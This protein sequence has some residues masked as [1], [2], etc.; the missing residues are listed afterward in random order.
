M[1]TLQFKL[2]AVLRQRQAIEDLRQRELALVMRQRMILLDQLKREQETITQSKHELGQALVGRVDLERVSGFA[3]FSGQTT[4]RATQIVRKLASLES[5]VEKARLALVEAMR[6]RKALDLLKEKHKRAW[7][8]RQD[9]L[10]AALLDELAVQRH[11]RMSMGG[12][13]V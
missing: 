7:Q 13:P 3:R 10:E 11:A 9:R 6:D 2:A 5:G 12:E 8:L 1:A 4:Q